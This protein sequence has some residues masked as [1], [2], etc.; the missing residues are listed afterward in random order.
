MQ[1]WGWRRGYPVPSS[2]SPAKHLCR[3]GLPQGELHVCA[4]SRSHWVWCWGK[5]DAAPCSRN[6]GQRVSAQVF[7]IPKSG[8]AGRVF[9][10]K[11]N[12]FALSCWLLI[13][14]KLQLGS[15][16][17]LITLLLVPNGF[18][19]ADATQVRV[20]ASAAR[21]W[22]AVMCAVCISLCC[23][24]VSDCFRNAPKHS[25]RVLPRVCWSKAG[26]VNAASFSPG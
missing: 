15:S 1:R 14:A 11:F 9:R 6:V 17:A 22:A 8:W 7:L 19:W 2:A 12:L 16:G 3:T 10:S 20:R 24:L 5:E 26:H 25:A 4:L 18:R 23:C 21:N 13:I